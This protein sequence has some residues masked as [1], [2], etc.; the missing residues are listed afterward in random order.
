MTNLDLEKARELGI[1]SPYAVGFMPYNEVNGKIRT[2]L[3]AAKRQLAMDSASRNHSERRRS[4]R[5]LHLPRPPHCGDPVRCYQ[6][7]PL[8]RSGEEGKLD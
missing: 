1:S 6:R 3:D 4:V 8:L 7:E 2:D 5:A